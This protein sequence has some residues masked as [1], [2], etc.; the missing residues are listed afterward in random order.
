MKRSTKALERK[1]YGLISNARMREEIL[2]VN[3][4]IIRRLKSLRYETL[5]KISLQEEWHN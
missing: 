2:Q 1:K 4:K 5:D 3:M